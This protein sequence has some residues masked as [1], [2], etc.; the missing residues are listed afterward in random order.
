MREFSVQAG[1]YSAEFADVA[2]GVLNLQSKSGTNQWHG[3]AFEFFR[4]DKLH[5]ADFFSNATGQPKNPL[6]YNQFGGAIG[7]PIRRDK[8]FV[9]ADYQGTIT[10][11]GTPMLTSLPTGPERQGD[12][13]A[14]G[15]FRSTIR[16][17][18]SLARTPFTGNIIPPSLIDPAAAKSRSFS[19]NRTSSLLTDSLFPSTTT[20]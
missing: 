14:L 2:G 13:S 3:S 20:P 5:A 16:S 15:R 7:G 6:R 9:F 17:E 11:S 18:P 4:N 1:A 19:R 8:T 10:H 12:F